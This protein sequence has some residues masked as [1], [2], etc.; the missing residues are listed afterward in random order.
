MEVKYVSECSV[1][2][3]DCRLRV[4]PIDERQGCTVNPL[5]RTGCGQV[6]SRVDLAV[7]LTTRGSDVNRIHHG[8]IDNGACSFIEWLRCRVACEAVTRLSTYLLVRLE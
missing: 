4:G 1:Q 8:F 5:H 6:V 2:T 3:A 7:V